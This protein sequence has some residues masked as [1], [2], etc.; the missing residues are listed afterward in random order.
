M[1]CA[2]PVGL[3]LALS[4]PYRKIVVLDGDGALLMKLG[5]LA[6]VSS[7]A[8]TNLLH[9][10]SNDGVYASTGGQANAAGVVSLARLALAAGYASAAPAET[11]AELEGALG[12][13]ANVAGPHMIEVAT[14]F[15]PRTEAPRVDELP[16]TYARRLRALRLCEPQV[17][18]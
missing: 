3:G 2:A 17:S 11:V 12:A 7:H 6:S 4:A 1:G 13:A 5:A 9:V 10:V 16:P 8:P 18:P 15:E 14:T